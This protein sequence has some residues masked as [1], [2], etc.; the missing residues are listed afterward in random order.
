[1]SSPKPSKSMSTTPVNDPPQQRLVL[2]KHTKP[3]LDAALPAHSWQLS[4]E[5][6]E[7]CLRLAEWLKAYAPHRIFTSQETKAAE[8]GHLVAQRLGLPCE[9][10]PG[11]H[12]HERPQPGLS[13]LEAF[14]ANVRLLFDRPSEIVFGSESADQAY[15]R[16]S[17]AIDGLLEKWGKQAG[18]LVVVA[19]GTVI[20]LFVSRRC[21]LEPFPL[22]QSL[23]LP[24]AV[25]IDLMDD[26]RLSDQ[27]P[28][29]HS[30]F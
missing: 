4:P 2:V 23:G 24:S 15:A 30:Q 18:A 22:W 3:V 6:R 13:S 25:V 5:G 1:M 11:L 26:G 21:G 29:I 8:T 14:H 10:F 19:H 7:S 16:F 20:S 28:L 12:E 9:S 17:S 27:P